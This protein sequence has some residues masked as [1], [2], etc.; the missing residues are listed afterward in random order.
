MDSPDVNR[1]L[2]WV[3][4]TTPFSTAIPSRAIK[5]TEAGTERYS[6][7]RAN[8]NTPPTNANGRFKKIIPAWMTDPKLSVRMMKIMIIDSGITSPSRAAARCWFSN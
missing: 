4:M 1:S 7:D 2:K 8:A 3:T 6:P 5:P